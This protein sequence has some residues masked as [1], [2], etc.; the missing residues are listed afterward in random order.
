MVLAYLRENTIEFKLALTY[1][2]SI[3]APWIFNIAFN[4]IK[5]TLTG[6]TMS[7]IHIFNHDETKWKPF[8]LEFM[9]ESQFPPEFYETDK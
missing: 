4:F 3:L 5:P 9:D 7:K 8:L 6:S 2:F 1:I